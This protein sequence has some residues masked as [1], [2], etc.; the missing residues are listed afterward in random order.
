MMI[1]L[2]K[3]KKIVALVMFVA[4]AISLVAFF[5]NMGNVADVF[6]YGSGFNGVANGVNYLITL[7]FMP[8]VLFTLGLVALFIPRPGN[9]N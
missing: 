5:M 3:L 1:L 2:W 4:A 7:L 9:N 6:R 8:L